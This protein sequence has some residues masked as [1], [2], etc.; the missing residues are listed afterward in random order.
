MYGLCAQY[1]PCVKGKSLRL[2]VRGRSARSAPCIHARCPA[3]KHCKSALRPHR[4]ETCASTRSHTFDDQYSTCSAHPVVAEYMRP[5]SE[6]VMT[7]WS[8]HLR[9]TS[10]RCV[11]CT[12]QVHIRL[13]SDRSAIRMA[14]HLG[15]SA[16]L[17]AIA[18][19][20][21]DLG[22]VFC[23]RRRVV[24]RACPDIWFCW[25]YLLVLMDIEARWPYYPPLHDDC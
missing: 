2:D 1:G 25:S 7:C 20:R 17:H 18:S 9:V 14:A 21:W 22:G 11:G 12:R 16:A 4:R 6:L 19:V 8:L 13:A 23:R 24:A 10:Q 3:R 5:H 15:T